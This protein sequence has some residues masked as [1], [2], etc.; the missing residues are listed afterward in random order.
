MNKLM[1]VMLLLAF[2]VGSFGAY[3]HIAAQ[4]RAPR[5][6]LVPIALPKFDEQISQSPDALATKHILEGTYINSGFYGAVVA[7]GATVPTDTKLTVACPGTSGTC[8]IEADMWVQSDGVANDAYAICLY[9]DGNPPAN[10]CPLAGETPAD[11]TAA[12]GSFSQSLSGLA[13]GNHTV[14]TYYFTDQ[15]AGVLDYTINY[16]VYK[17]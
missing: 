15:G 7:A 12:I 4:E 17:P 11:G 16:R 13:H 8:T 3:R 6:G 1:K 14:Q 10:G 9:V 2:A 5:K